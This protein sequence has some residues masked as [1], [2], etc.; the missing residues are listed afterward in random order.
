LL[1]EYFGAERLGLTSGSIQDVLTQLESAWGT[2]EKLISE[3]FLSSPLKEKYRDLVVR[4][5]HVLD[6]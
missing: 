2:W 1:V 3:S 5:R 4:R 6:F